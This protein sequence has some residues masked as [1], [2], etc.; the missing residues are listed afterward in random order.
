VAT[1][2]TRFLNNITQPD[3]STFSMNYNKIEQDPATAVVTCS[4][5]AG[6]L[7]KMT[8]PTGG[9]VQY[10]LKQ[11]RFPDYPDDV[12]KG[13][14]GTWRDHSISVATRSLIDASNTTLGTWTYHADLTNPMLNVQC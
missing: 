10:T 11:R 13:T 9:S 2:S 6:H 14:P 12:A 7:L 1:T 4:L 3:G 8:L 5:K